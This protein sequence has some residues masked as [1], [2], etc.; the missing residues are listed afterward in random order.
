MASLLTRLDDSPRG[1]IVKLLQKF[2]PLD[3]KELRQE[4]NLSDTAV[5]QQLLTLLAEG[6]IQ[7]STSTAKGV[8]RPS[9]VY[10]LTAASSDLFA[11]YCE[12]LALN[13]YNELLADQGPEVV[14][15]LLDRVGAKLALQYQQQ[16]RGQA[17][18]ERVRSFATLLDDKGILSDISQDA[19]VI[20][21]HEFNCPYHELAAVH[22]QIC[23][24]EQGMIA[25]VLDARLN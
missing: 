14:R 17:L 22:R 6:L 20:M 2:G 25:Q 1:K 7:S 11:C 8:G 4:L 21:L 16:V 13:L 10:E 18:Q 12:D 24:M 9:R 15:L 23:E 5:R 3:I 19:D